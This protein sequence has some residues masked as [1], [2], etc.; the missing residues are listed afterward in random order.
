MS[1]NENIKW[2]QKPIS[3]IILIVLFFPVGLYL[4]WKNRLW[5]KSV[6]ILVTIF[7]V[8]FF[9]YTSSNSKSSDITTFSNENTSNTDSDGYG[10][11]SDFSGWFSGIS[12]SFNVN[13]STFSGYINDNNNVERYSGRTIGKDLVMDVDGTGQEVKVGYISGDKLYIWYLGNYQPIGK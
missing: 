11:Y 5:S 2:Y 9:I 13:S 3:I 1:Q 10:Q 7:M 12:G 6:R 4:M 8:G